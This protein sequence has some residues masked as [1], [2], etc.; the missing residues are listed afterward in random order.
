VLTD[1]IDIDELKHA[2]EKAKGGWGMYEYVYGIVTP[3]EKFISGCFFLFFKFM[4]Y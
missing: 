4:Q 2:Q 1:I 3:G